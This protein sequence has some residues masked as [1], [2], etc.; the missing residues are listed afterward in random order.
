MIKSYTVLIL[1]CI[2]ISCTHS[3]QTEIWKEEILN[4][5]REFSAM[6]AREGIAEAFINFADED[7]VLMRNNELIKSRDSISS[8][9]AGRMDTGLSWEPDFVEVSESGDL[10]YTY[11]QYSYTYQ[12]TDGDTA[13]VTGIFHTVWKRQSDGG[14]KFV[15]D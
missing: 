7:A 13:T 8:F 4:T 15:W 14:W 2:I 11:G 12:N 9:Y 10:G 6:A 3:D 1:I 5:E